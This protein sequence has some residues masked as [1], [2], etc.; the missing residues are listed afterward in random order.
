MKKLFS[1]SLV[2]ASLF[3]FTGVVYAKGNSGMDE[4]LS[5]LTNK[6]V[7]EIEKMHETES[8]R[9]IAESASVTEE[10]LAARTQVRIDRINDRLEAGIITKEEAASLIENAKTNTDCNGNAK[11]RLNRHGN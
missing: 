2:I 4:L 3:L 10:F 8:Y 9:E 1:A 7:E 6:S 11:M 5:K